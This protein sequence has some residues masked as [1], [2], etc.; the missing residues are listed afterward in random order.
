MRAG[1]VVLL[2]L[3]VLSVMLASGCGPKASPEAGGETCLSCHSDEAKLLAD[4]A[5]D[6]P[7]EKPKAESEGEG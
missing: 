3:L 2:S 4:L 7:A 5:S 1:K 6:P